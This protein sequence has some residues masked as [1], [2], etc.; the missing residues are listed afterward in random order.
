[1]L[2]E[3]EEGAVR[4]HVAYM[5]ARAASWAKY[6]HDYIGQLM[7]LIDTARVLFQLVNNV[8]YERRVS[9]YE[10]IAKTLREAA[11]VADGLAAKCREYNAMVKAPA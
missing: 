5:K 3:S 6:D 10:D 7:K 1:M 11:D 4:R 8:P 9:D 2:S